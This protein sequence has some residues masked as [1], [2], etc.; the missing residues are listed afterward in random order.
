VSP[1]TP[2]LTPAE[3]VA[4]LRARYPL[5]LIC[6]SREACPSRVIATRPERYAKSGR[7][8]DG[9]RRPLTDSER[10]SYV[11]ARCREA[12]AER[13]QA[14]AIRAETGRANLA[15]ARAKKCVE[16]PDP[17]PYTDSTE[18]PPESDILSLSCNG[19]FR[20]IG[21][22]SPLDHAGA[23]LRRLSGRGGRPATGMSRSARYRHRRRLIDP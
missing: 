9:T 15:R 18:R 11:C 3:E 22:V 16:T 20:S 7:E 13:A 5:G 21:S 17:Y 12:I 1:D 19:G 6:T 2:R 10:L 4:R 8:R 14:A 23:R